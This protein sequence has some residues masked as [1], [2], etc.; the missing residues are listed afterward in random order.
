LKHY[1]K[2]IGLRTNYPAL[3]TGTYQEINSAISAVY[4]FLRQHQESNTTLLLV[5]NT[6]TERDSFPISLNSSTLTEGT[7][8]LRDLIT[9]TII[10]SINVTSNGGFSGTNEAI[11]LMPFTS[12]ALAIEVQ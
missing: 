5:H 3:S 11:S 1:Q 12:Y 10:G 8:N 9:N 6:G 2:W 4:S 7:Y